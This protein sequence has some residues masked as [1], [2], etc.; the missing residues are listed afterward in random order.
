[1][2][3]Q[4]D[5]QVVYRNGLMAGIAAVVS[6]AWILGTIGAAIGGRSEILP[7]LIAMDLT[8]L[9]MVMYFGAIRPRVVL[10]GSEVE[11]HGYLFSETIPYESI[12][13]VA[14]TGSFAGIRWLEIDRGHGWMVGV[15]PFMATGTPF[16]DPLWQRPLAAELNER[17]E[18]DGQLAPSDTYLLTPRVPR[19]GMRPGRPRRESARRRL[20]TPRL[21]RLR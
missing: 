3:Y 20:K 15:H 6:S 19:G 12:K 11:I 1:M 16:F 14:F 5:S 18:L 10:K 4:R 17:A 21:I 13:S 7:M 2:R 9:P 8:V